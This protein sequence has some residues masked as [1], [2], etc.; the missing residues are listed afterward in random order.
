MMNNGDMTFTSNPVGFEVG[1]VGDLNNDGFLDMLRDNALRMNTGNGNHWIRVQPVGTVSNRNAIGARVTITTAAGS[2]VREI[3]SGDG[4][5]FMSTLA[6][7]FG[8]GQET[9]IEEVSVRFPSGIV[10]TVTDPPIDGTLTIVEGIITAMGSPTVDALRVHPVPTSGTLHL[11]G[12]LDQATVIV[13]DV[14][15]RALLRTAVV[16][17]VLD[18][19]ALVP[20]IYLLMVEDADGSRQVRFVKE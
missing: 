7:H 14:Q 4:F 8:I 10:N 9:A 16:A 5:T 12:V 6:A 13:H 11:D 20:G 1:A 17:G 19:S 2:Q 15:G 3:R 18:V